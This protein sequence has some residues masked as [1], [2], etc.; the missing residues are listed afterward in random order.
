MKEIAEKCKRQKFYPSKLRV[1]GKKWGIVASENIQIYV[2]TLK[3]FEAGPVVLGTAWTLDRIQ[4][5][6]EVPCLLSAVFK[7]V[8][9]Q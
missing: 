7:M 8:P 1:S 6:R 3:I 4:V 9:G 5:S 2:G